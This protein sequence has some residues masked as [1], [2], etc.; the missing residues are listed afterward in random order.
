MTAMKIPTADRSADGTLGNHRGALS[1][2][3]T[4]QS[5]VDLCRENMEDVPNLPNATCATQ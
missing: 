4:T 2:R 5:H 1:E 3:G